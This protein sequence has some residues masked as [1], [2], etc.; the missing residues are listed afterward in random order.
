[1]GLEF[2]VDENVLIPR[3]DTEKLVE[4]VLKGP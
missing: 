2:T 1:M 3:Q 4:T